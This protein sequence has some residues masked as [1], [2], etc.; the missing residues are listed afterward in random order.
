MRSEEMRG[1]ETE[2]WEGVRSGTG[3]IKEGNAETAAA[4]KTTRNVRGKSQEQDLRRGL[5]G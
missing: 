3:A 1:I 4:F 5:S 2:R